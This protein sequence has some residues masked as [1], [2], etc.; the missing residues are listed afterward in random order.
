M[1][2][3]SWYLRGSRTSFVITNKGEG[4]HWFRRMVKPGTLTSANIKVWK[5]S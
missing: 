4:T 5:V 1:M 3:V 2:E